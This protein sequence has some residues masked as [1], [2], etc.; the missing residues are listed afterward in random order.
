MSVSNPS[1]V[2]VRFIQKCIKTSPLH[3]L[4]SISPNNLISPYPKRTAMDSTL[5]ED[6]RHGILVPPEILARI[7]SSLLESYSLV[8]TKETAG[9][10]RQEALNVRMASQVCLFWRKVALSGSCAP[11]W[12]TIIN[13]DSSSEFW[14]EELLFRSGRAP[15]LVQSRPT[16]CATPRSLTSLKWKLLLCE[17]HRIQRLDLTI[18]SQEAQE[19][20][21]LFLQ[22]APMLESLALRSDFETPSSRR[23]R[24]DSGPVPLILPPG[25]RLF[26]NKSP[27]LCIT[28]DRVLF[29]SPTRNLPKPLNIVRLNLCFPHEPWLDLISHLIDTSSAPPCS[30]LVSY[31]NSTAPILVLRNLQELTLRGSRIAFQLLSHMSIPH[32]SVVTLSIIQD[33]TYDGL[34]DLL[35]WLDDY[36]FSWKIHNDPV[37]TWS[38]STSRNGW[39]A[40]H[41]KTTPR[42]VLSL[43][44][45][46]TLTITRQSPSSAF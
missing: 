40:F 19:L 44:S 16:L 37:H 27:K 36:F 14:V 5:L 41:Q 3:L 7:F 24:F 17:L 42:I 43:C 28:L 38:L 32:S 35:P 29:C 23:N 46:S 39:F 34:D 15:L 21:P 22:P 4:I 31:A 18:G 1:R 13:V 11:I 9:A 2:G 10:L 33:S 26:G 8:Y 30:S 6:A 45:S 25:K 12:G 20:A